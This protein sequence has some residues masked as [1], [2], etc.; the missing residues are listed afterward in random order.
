MCDSVCLFYLLTYLQ[1]EALGCKWGDNV[2]RDPLYVSSS[3]QLNIRYLHPPPQR[4]LSLITHRFIHRPRVLHRHGVSAGASPES[5]LAS[6]YRRESAVP[7]SRFS[8]ATLE[9]SRFL[10]AQRA[11]APVSVVVCGGVLRASARGGTQAQYGALHV[12][13]RPG[14]RRR[15]Y[16]DEA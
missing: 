13:D 7:S 11:A 9:L 8:D 5:L 10:F 3:P 12:R 14:C 15:K 6:G 2:P 1:R 16:G 4:N